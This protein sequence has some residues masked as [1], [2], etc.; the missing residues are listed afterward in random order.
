MKNAI[1][2]SSLA[3]LAMGHGVHKMGKRDLPFDGSIVYACTVPG[4]VALTFDDGPFDY[5]Q[6]IVDALTAAGHKATFFQNGQ[7]YGSIFDYASVLQSMIAGGHQIGSHTWA[8]T[9]LGLMTNADDI[10][11]AMQQ[12]EDAHVQIIGKAP[13]YMRPPYLST[14]DLATSTLA[15]LKF[16]II[17]VD[18]D[19]FDYDEGPAGLIQNSIDWYEGNQTAG[20]TLSLNHDPYIT[21]AQDFVPAIIKYLDGKGLK[22]VPVGECLGDAPEN[23]YRTNG[24]VVT[25]PSSTPSAP[26]NGTLPT[27]GSKPTGSGKPGSPGK[28]ITWTHTKPA[29]GYPKPTGPYKP[30]KGGDTESGH[31]PYSGWGSLPGSWGKGNDNGCDNGTE[32]TT[33]STWTPS[34]GYTGS[35]TNSSAGSAPSYYVNSANG[36][37]SSVVG[38]IAVAALALFL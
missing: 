13:T 6:T 37:A 24:T 18:I 11:A 35:K 28:P 5:T 1:I 3:G 8:H 38:V 4:T 12:L 20:G 10:V 29:G 21:T 7:N 22:S 17:S 33:G 2:A 34:G 23:W 26:S 16:H 30:V 25:S 27:G 15:A 36:L 14:S 19:T 32:D 31:G 9:D